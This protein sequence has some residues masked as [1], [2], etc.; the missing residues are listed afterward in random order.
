MADK[1]AIGV[2]EEPYEMLVERGKIREFA[3]ATN[4]RNPEYLDDPHAVSPPTFLTTS[5]FWSPP[6]SAAFRAAK[7]DMKRLL[8]GE[9]EYVFHGAPPK[10][11]TKLTV[12]SRIEDIFEKVGKRGGTMTFVISVQEFRDETGRLV[13]EARS[14]AI[15]TGRA[16]TEESR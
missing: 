8:H 1:A 3:R 11:G 14:T 15:E 4:S 2:T 16:P 12:Q 13:A 5:Q 7:I 10:A 9:Q 6:D